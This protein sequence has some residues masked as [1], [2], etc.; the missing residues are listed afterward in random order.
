M[1]Q[2]AVKE[3]RLSA[4]KTAGSAHLA[5]RNS[6]CT[7]L[8]HLESFLCDSPQL[9]ASRMPPLLAALRLAQAAT[10]CSPACSPV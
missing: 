8:A 7:K 4:F 2:A 1:H 6:L 10:S 5:A 9:L 3:S